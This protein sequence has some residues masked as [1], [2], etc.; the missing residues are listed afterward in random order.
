MYLSPNLKICS[1][2]QFIESPLSQVNTFIGIPLDQNNL[3]QIL[4]THRA[5]TISSKSTLK[6]KLDQWFPNFLFR[7]PNIHLK[8]VCGSPPLRVV[9][10]YNDC[11][12]AVDA[13]QVTVAQWLVLLALNCKVMSS[14][15]GLGV[16]L[17]CS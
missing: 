6:H 10:F 11:I 8:M 14:M 1:S 16:F 3:K 2:L 12:S 9:T 13:V 17:L 7:G 4:L 5:L 15:P